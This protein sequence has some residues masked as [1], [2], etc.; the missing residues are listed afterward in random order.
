VNAVLKPI[1]ARPR[2]GFLG[3]GWIGRLRL[4]ALA[5]TGIADIVAVA[6]THPDAREV[7][8]ACAPG[9]SA[10]D[11]LDY[12]LDQDLDGIVI[13]TPSALHAEQARAALARGIAVFAQKPLTRTVDEAALVI[14]A[15]RKSNRLL[16]VD[17]CYRHVAG[18]H[19]LRDRIGS[20]EL[21][22][23]YAIDLVFHNAYGPDK[24]WFYDIRQSGGGC[25]MDLGSHLVDMAL[26]VSGS[27]GFAALDAQL[28]A[29]GQ[30][31]L[32]PHQTAEDYATV[33][34]TLD[35]GTSVRMS[36]SWRLPAGRDAVIEMAF[37]GTHG[38]AALR[39]VAGSF[40]DF[41]VERY[42]G[43]HSE[44]LAAGPDAW[45]GR[46]LVQ[47]TQRIGAGEGFDQTEAAHLLDVARSMD[48]IYAR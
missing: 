21:G 42:Q 9:A 46:A 48:R 5:A 17:F 27:G 4:Q 47:W 28:Y 39:N 23:L 6:D 33:L 38:G 8:V 2:I 3:V 44:C 37:Y 29:R 34:G 20:G 41:R 26:W 31:L 1:A 40:Y 13:A 18:L 11:C 7:A 32:P 25:A 16:G 24:P 30:R 19:E 35:V 10:G 45:G 12:L 36:C 15:A 14:A 22:R 43:T